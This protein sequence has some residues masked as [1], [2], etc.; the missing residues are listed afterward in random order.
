[1]KRVLGAIIILVTVIVFAIWWGFRPDPINK[2]IKSDVTLPNEPSSLKGMAPICQDFFNELQPIPH[3]FSVRQ[4]IIQNHN[5]RLKN[6]SIIQDLLS[7]F[8]QQP[9]GKYV[10]YVDVFNSD[11]QEEHANDIFFQV[12][13]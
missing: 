3:R 11:F 12:S 6:V 4:L 7:C 5:E 9:L 13:V 1:M 8:S 10:F 2:L